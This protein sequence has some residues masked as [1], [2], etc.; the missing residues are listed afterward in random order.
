MQG[1]LRVAR[2]V[3]APVRIYIPF[4]ISWLPYAL[5]HVQK[6]PRVAW[7]AVLD[8]TVGRFVTP[9]SL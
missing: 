8:A 1:A 4:G 3:R 6:N 7:W 5:L 9:P 2:E